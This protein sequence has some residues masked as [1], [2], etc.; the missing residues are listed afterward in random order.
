MGANRKGERRDGWRRERGVSK[1]RGMQEERGEVTVGEMEKL[2][3]AEMTERGGDRAKRGEEGSR[4]S[5]LAL[6]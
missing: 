3:G 2:R 4:G 1:E 6:G 5:T